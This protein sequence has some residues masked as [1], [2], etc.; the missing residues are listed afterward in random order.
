[1]VLGDVIVAVDDKPINDVKDLFAVL[2]R[3]NVGDTA[4][5]AIL[6]DGQRQNFRIALEAME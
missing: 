3:Y 1:M 5:L 4:T 6:R 2:E